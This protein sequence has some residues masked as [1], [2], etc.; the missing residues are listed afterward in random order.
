MFNL[1][2]CG[3]LDE[4]QLRSINIFYSILYLNYHNLLLVLCIKWPSCIYS[5]NR[6]SW[7]NIIIF[8]LYFS[9][10]LTYFK[11]CCWCWVINSDTKC[12]GRNYKT[13]NF[14]MI[15]KSTSSKFPFFNISLNLCFVIFLYFLL[16]TIALSLIL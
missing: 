10:S 9:L 13:N 1:W 12:G 14:L 2:N 3:D 11:C 16:L 7:L 8:Y 5:E 15:I 4:H 6:S